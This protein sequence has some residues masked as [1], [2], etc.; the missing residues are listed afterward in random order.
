VSIRRKY[1]CDFWDLENAFDKVP[2]KRL[3]EKIEKHGIGGKLRRIIKNW[4]QSRRQRVCISGKMSGWM[5]VLSGVPQ[6]SV[7]EDLLFLIYIKSLD[8]SILNELLKFATFRNVPYRC[9][10]LP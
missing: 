4:L 3:I 2:H 5:S 6:E 1:R 10:M 8:L 9:A 7:L